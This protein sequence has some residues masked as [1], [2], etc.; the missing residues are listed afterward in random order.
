MTFGLDCY[1]IPLIANKDGIVLFGHIPLRFILLS[2]SNAEPRPLRTDRRL[3]P[4]LLSIV[5][6]A[7]HGQLRTFRANEIVTQN[8]GRARFQ[9]D[10]TLKEDRRLR[11]RREVAFRRKEK[12][13]EKN[14]L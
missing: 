12:A 2:I 8:E 13:V 4:L 3:Q 11:R 14:S 10:E 9:A 6:K 5:Q 7:I 1:I